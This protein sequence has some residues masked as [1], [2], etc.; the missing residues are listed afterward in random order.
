M[1]PR[2]AIP[3]LMGLL[4]VGLRADP[5]PGENWLVEGGFEHPPPSLTAESG[6]IAGGFELSGVTVA[7]VT[8][9]HSGAYSLSVTPTDPSSSSKGGAYLRFP[10]SVP[11]EKDQV[12]KFVFSFWAKTESDPSTGD[13]ASFRHHSS[14][15]GFVGAGGGF[16]RTRW[17]NL[18]DWTHLGAVYTVG[19]SPVAWFRFFFETSRP[20]LH[21]FL[22]D[23]RF[24]EVTG[25]PDDAIRKLLGDATTTPSMVLA[26]TGPQQTDYRKGNLLENS[27]FELAANHGWGGAT[28]QKLEDA[29]RKTSEHQQ[30]IACASVAAGDGLY[31]K[32]ISLRP[33]RKHTFSVQAKPF[34]AGAKLRVDIFNL[35][36]D[37]SRL[38]RE[39][40][41]FSEFPL[42]DAAWQRVSFTFVPT[43]N[44]ADNAYALRLRGNAWVDCVQ[45]EEGDLSEF[46]P[47]GPLESGIVTSKPNNLFA[48]D[49]PLAAELQVVNYTD[50]EL[51]WEGTLVVHN[52]VE[53][54]VHRQDVAIRAPATSLAR[55]AITL[56]DHLRGALRLTLAPKNPA[57]D[58]AE[59]VVSRVPR[60]RHLEPWPQSKFGLF[61]LARE[62]LARTGQLLGSKW[63]RDHHV[64]NW[65]RIQAQRGTYDFSAAEQVVSCNQQAGI[66]VFGSLLIDEDPPWAADLKARGK[67]EEFWTAW[68]EFT[69]AVARHFT[70][71]VDVWEVG[72]E[73]QHAEQ[74]VEF[75]R[76]THAGLKRGNPRCT[77]MG[78]SSTPA[79]GAFLKEVVARGGLSSLDDVSSHIYAYSHHLYRTF[80]EYSALLGNKRVWSTEQGAWGGDTFYRTLGLHSP[81]TA[82][83][84]AR[85]YSVVAASPVVRMALYYWMS[86]GLILPSYRTPYFYEYDSAIKPE[87]VSFAV[88]AYS[89]E[90]AEPVESLFFNEA[91][92]AYLLRRG[93]RWIVTAWARE[94][95]PR[96]LRPMILRGHVLF[97]NVMG[98]EKNFAP[99]A[100]FACA[101]TEDVSYLEFERRED[102]Q[103]G[104][105]PAL[106]AAFATGEKREAL[107]RDGWLLQNVD[108][109]VAFGIARQEGSAQPTVLLIRDRPVGV[110]PIAGEMPHA[111]ERAKPDPELVLNDQYE[112]AALRRIVS[113][114]EGKVVILVD[115]KNG[116]ARATDTA[117]EFHLKAKRLP[118]AEGNAIHFESLAGEPMK[119]SLE[120]FAESD[121]KRA[122]A[123]QIMALDGDTFI[124]SLKPE[125]LPKVFNLRLRLSLSKGT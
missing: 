20:G 23:L 37:S 109:G 57:A 96:P 16:P 88:C 27:S 95:G 114:Q 82:Q 64:F 66:S 8:N 65:R 19:P 44:T 1:K 58:R 112:E 13:F 14:S 12:R 49:E 36:H 29:I 125:G 18:Q 59:L 113:I 3:L 94:G 115:L 22:D 79:S 2:F 97:R 5:L 99:G 38:S 71:R 21:V 6:A 17:K 77:V 25:L 42:K 70:G 62:D 110:G 63:T 122:V 73:P 78:L 116:Y 35:Q 103:E 111:T 31:Y 39:A 67:R 119:F 43:P 69:E 68:E 74:Y 32:R 76:H 89:L 124:L 30:G 56:P 9:A 86:P 50:H 120:E 117:F 60:P 102:I 4:G 85:Y 40:E 48:W 105:V 33:F 51:T 107:Q 87:G 92:Q 72:I 11:V 46:T 45:M 93:N 80:G 123:W 118:R 121:R 104:F 52:H 61:T 7:W 24:I 10:I 41:I 100:P 106:S 15:A 53:E 101:I 75:A 108:N 83:M 34:Q 26:A 98:I 55:Q 28:A 54:V 90:D 91:A 47:R 84:S 81:P